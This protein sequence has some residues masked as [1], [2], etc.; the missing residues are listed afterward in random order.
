MGKLNYMIQAVKESSNLNLH[1]TIIFN[2]KNS[3]FP[4]SKILVYPRTNLRLGKSSKISV[5]RGSLRVG[6]KWDGTNYLDSN[7]K[8][9]EDA[10]LVINNSFNFYTGCQINVNKGS[11]LEIGSGYTNTEVTIDCFN[12]IKIGNGVVISKGAIIRDSDNHK[13]L[14]NDYEMSKPIIIGDH[15]W[16]GMRA[17][18][19]KGVKIGDGSIIAAG[20]VVNKDVPPYCMVAGVPAKIKKEGIE[21]R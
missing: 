14:Y 4:K 2:I 1:K 15:V 20:A 5:E 9:D 13:I 12:N 10:E 18:I 21:W 16:I 6:I 7:L 17:I 11:T 3:N 8:I 19:L